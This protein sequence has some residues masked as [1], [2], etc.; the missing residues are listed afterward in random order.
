MHFQPATNPGQPHAWE[1]VSAGAYKA[2]AAHHCGVSRAVLAGETGEQTAFHVRYFEIGPGGNTSLEHHTHE[3]FV[4]VFRGRGEVRLGDT[5]H[6]LN[7]GDAVYIGPDE[8]H[9]LRNTSAEEPFGFFCTV[10]ARRDTPVE[11]KPSA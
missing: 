2:P 5:V 10:D 3:H 1:G 11:V 8:V 4:I 9:Q 6:A 7:F